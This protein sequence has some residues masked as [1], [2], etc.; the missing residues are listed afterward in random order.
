MLFAEEKVDSICKQTYKN[1]S[2]HKSIAVWS[3]RVC[4]FTGAL[5][6]IGVAFGVNV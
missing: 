6:L 5:L 4:M 3:A 1:A 2:D